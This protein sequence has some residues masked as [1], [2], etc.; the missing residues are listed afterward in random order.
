MSEFPTAPPSDFP[1]T[2][3]SDYIPAPTPSAGPLDALRGFVQGTLDPALGTVRD[4]TGDFLKSLLPMFSPPGVQAG[5]GPLGGGVLESAVDLL[6]PIPG[7]T[8]DVLRD[9]GTLA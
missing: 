4:G 1:T 7:D 5:Q 9:M 2:I 6:N 3:P 8:S